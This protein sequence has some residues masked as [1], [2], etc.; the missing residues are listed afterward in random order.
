[1]PNI[2]GLSYVEALKRL[3]GAGLFISKSSGLSGPGMTVG[4]QYTE[5]GEKV[6]Y[7]SV[8]EV[9]LVDESRQGEY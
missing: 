8:I 9:A 2:S 4:T 7:G 1:M 6:P 3:Q 5:A